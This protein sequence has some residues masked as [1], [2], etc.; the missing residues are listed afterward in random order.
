MII[1]DNYVI[2]TIIVISKISKPYISKHS[3]KRGDVYL[4]CSDGVSDMLTEAEIVEII[5]NSDT[6]EH[7]A[8]ALVAGA[9]WGGGRDNITVIVCKII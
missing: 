8:D 2:I 1:V 3:L 5:Q 7:C 9:L 4:I 6:A